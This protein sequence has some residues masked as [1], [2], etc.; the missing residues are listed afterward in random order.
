MDIDSKNVEIGRGSY[1]TVY[2][3]KKLHKVYKTFSLI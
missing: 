2:L 1:G 3:N